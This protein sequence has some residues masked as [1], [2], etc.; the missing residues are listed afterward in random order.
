[1]ALNFSASINRNIQKLEQKINDRVYTI[2]IEL[3]NEIVRRT[4]SPATPGKTATGLLANQWYPKAGAGF[5][6]SEGTD[7]SPNGAS[8][9]ARIAALR[10]GIEFLGKNGRL[11]LTNNVH[12]A[13]RA[14]VLG[15]P[16][17]DGWSGN[18]VAYR[19]VALSLQH[20]A[21]RHR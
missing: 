9:R 15:W 16:L 20:I 5:S 6:G 11:T 3:F 21:A 7:T 19:M 10:G 14:E 2:S 1:M 18:V 12:Y 8:S 17:A 13:Y 4:P